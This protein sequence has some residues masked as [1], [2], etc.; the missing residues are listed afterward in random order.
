MLQAQLVTTIYNQ[1][2]V[3]E[4]ILKT[5]LTA[6]H[7]KESVGSIQVLNRDLL[8]R[9]IHLEIKKSNNLAFSFAYKK[10]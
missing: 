1:N 9:A 3:E 8:L 10:L 5:G 4:L 2:R 7:Y 6:H